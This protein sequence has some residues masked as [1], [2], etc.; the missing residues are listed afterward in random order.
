MRIC[1]IPLKTEPRNPE[2][3]LEHLRHRLQEVD[4]YKPD[5]V[6]LPE[7]TLTGYLYEKEDLSRFAE[8]ISGKTISQLS[9][10]A[11]KYGVYLCCGFLESTP[12]D[13]FNTAVLL[14]TAGRLI[15]LHRKINEQP[16]FANGHTVK[17]AFTAMGKIAL[18][19]CGDL[20]DTGIVEKIETP[21]DLLI[22]P[23]ARS[24][25]TKSPDQDRWLTEERSIY[26]NAVRKTRCQTAIVNAW[27]P[28]VEEGAF[29]GALVVNAEGHLLAETPHGTDQILSYDF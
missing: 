17:S 6:C 21:I 8:P 23:M 25:T 27:E 10:L 7:C 24:F 11:I 14:D 29:G 20:F 15:H 22:V 9:N 5:L 19:V 28:G 3:N 18:L 12:T 26:L 4:R 13:V 1:L 2:A 16:P